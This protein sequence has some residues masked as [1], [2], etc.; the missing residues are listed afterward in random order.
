MVVQRLHKHFSTRDI[1]GLGLPCFRALLLALAWEGSRSRGPPLSIHDALCL[2]GSVESYRDLT[3]H[4]CVL[5]LASNPSNT[6]AFERRGRAYS[7]AWR[8]DSVAR[9]SG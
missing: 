5:F 2:N 9:R 6:I 7:T 3:S 1:V 4:V 8:S